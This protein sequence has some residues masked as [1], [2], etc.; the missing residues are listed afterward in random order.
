MAIAP[1][2]DTDLSHDDFKTFVS[3]YLLKDESGQF[4][5]FWTTINYLFRGEFTV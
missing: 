1:F 2:L 3:H 5:A 4:G